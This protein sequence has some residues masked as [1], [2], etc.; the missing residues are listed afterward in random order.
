MSSANDVC[1]AVQVMMAKD[2][3]ELDENFVGPYGFESVAAYRKES[4]PLHVANNILTP[5]LAISAADDPVCAV[6]GAPSSLVESSDTLLKQPS[7][8]DDVSN[9]SASVSRMGPGLVVVRTK[10]GGHLGFPVLWRSYDQQQQQMLSTKSAVKRCWG[11]WLQSTWTDDVVV[12]W[13]N[14]F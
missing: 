8:V 11:R 14:Q 4:S 2:L 5:T 3:D 10:F 6:A 12:D 1:C 9:Q 13:F 7:S